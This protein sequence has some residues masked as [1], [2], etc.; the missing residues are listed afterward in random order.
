MSL[1]ISGFVLLLADIGDIFTWK[2]ASNCLYSLLQQCS[3]NPGL[4]VKEHIANCP[5]FIKK[6]ELKFKPN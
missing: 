2:N 3:C 4:Q 6:R 1:K 5:K